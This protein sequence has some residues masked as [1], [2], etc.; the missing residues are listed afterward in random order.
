MFVA[1]ADK[2]VS[3]HFLHR[4]LETETESPLS[5][6]NAITP[7]LGAK[8]YEPW[9]TLLRAIETILL[10]NLYLYLGC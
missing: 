7:C 5:S 3:V 2:C 6:L 10:G 4:Q 1:T 9:G 8:T